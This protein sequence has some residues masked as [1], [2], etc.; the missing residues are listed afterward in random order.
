MDTFGKRLHL[1]LLGYSHWFIY[2]IIS[3]LKDHFNIVD[4]DMYATY[5]VEE[6][7][8]TATIKENS[9]FHNTTLRHEIIFTKEY[10]YTSDKQV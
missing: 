6:Y 4:Q 1:N 7:L 9:E 2:I 10:D 8:E 5:V 3:H